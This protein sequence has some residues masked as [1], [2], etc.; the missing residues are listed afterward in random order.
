MLVSLKLTVVKSQPAS[1]RLPIINETKS[2]G[3]SATFSSGSIFAT[4]RP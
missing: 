2:P 1:P 3:R 4:L